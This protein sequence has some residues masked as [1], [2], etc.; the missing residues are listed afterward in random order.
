MSNLD[1]SDK[2]NFVHI[3]MVRYHNNLEDLLKQRK[4]TM[5]EQYENLNEH[6]IQ[7]TGSTTGKWI[8]WILVCISIILSSIPASILYKMHTQYLM[9]LSIKRM[10]LNGLPIAILFG[11]SGTVSFVGYML[12]IM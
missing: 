11:I 5:Q 9:D 1:D 10:L 7:N 4:N 6:I 12:G 3:N 2:G 8:K